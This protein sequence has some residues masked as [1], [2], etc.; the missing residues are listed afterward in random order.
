MNVQGDRES[1]A[2]SEYIINFLKRWFY[3]DEKFK[4]LILMTV[5]KSYLWEFEHEGAF[6][7]L[8]LFW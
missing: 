8:N 1:H 7:A 5:K 6:V 3:S 4:K 2:L